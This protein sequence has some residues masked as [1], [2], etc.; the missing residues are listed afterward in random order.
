MGDVNGLVMVEGRPG[1]GRSTTAAAVA[2]WLTDEVEVEVEHWAEGRADHPVDR[3]VGADEVAVLTTADLLA[4]AAE[5]P[6]SSS[7]LLGAAE[8]HG[9]AWLVRHARHDSLPPALVERVVAAS[10]GADVPGDVGAALV[11]DAWEAFGATEPRGVHVWESVLLRSADPALVARLVDAVRRHDPVLVYLDDGLDDASRQGQRRR[12]ELD[13]VAALDLPT[14]VVDV[15]DG[16]WDD[17]LATVRTFV[18][19]HLGLSPDA[20][21]VA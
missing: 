9:D 13:L 8:Q 4:I 19:E 12:L 18:A 5:S 3:P 7:A 17:H 16:R 21:Q 11:T 1:S 20:Q 15:G 10:L 14:L 2:A 6:E